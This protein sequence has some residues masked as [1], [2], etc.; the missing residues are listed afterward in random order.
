[1]TGL[2]EKLVYVKN[3]LEDDLSKEILENRIRLSHTILDSSRNVGFDEGYKIYNSSIIPELE[4]VVSDT[5]NILIAGAGK[6]G[7]NSLKKL[8]HAG[9]KVVGFL[10]NDQNKQGNYIDGVCVFPFEEIINRLSNCVIVIANDLYGKSYYNQVISYG[11]QKEKIYYSVNGRITSRFGQEYFDVPRH[12][13]GKKEVFVDAGSLNGKNCVEFMGWCNNEYERIFAIEPSRTS[14][15][16]VNSKLEK[17]RDICIVNAA[18][19]EE[20]GEISFYDILDHPG[21]SGG[22]NQGLSKEYKVRVDT[23]DHITN[24]FPVTFIKYDVEGSELSALKGSINTIQQYKP[25]LAVSVYH[26]EDDVVDIPIFINSIRND[27]KYFLR[28]YSD[29]AADLV[30][31]CI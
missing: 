7:I 12:A 13:I 9:Y 31:Y 6:V 10:D 3:L 1:M 16:M 28:H 29:T 21:A 14:I 2:V 11:F 25:A 19:G 30:L 15:K 27:Y 23:I 18:V 24:G 22:N 8:K 17:E 5:D 26:N 4:E 20:E